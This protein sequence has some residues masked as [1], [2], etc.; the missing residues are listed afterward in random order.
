[1]GEMVVRVGGVSVDEDIPVEPQDVL[2]CL[3]K[4]LLPIACRVRYEGK[5][6]V[7]L[8]SCQDPASDT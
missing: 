5:S 7:T 3:G 1:M 4:G 6:L 8:V 2:G